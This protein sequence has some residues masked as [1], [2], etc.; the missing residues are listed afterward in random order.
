[1]SITDRHRVL[2]AGKK[3]KHYLVRI[4]IPLKLSEPDKHKQNPVDQAIQNLKDGLSKISNA[5][6]KEVIAYH[7]KAMDYLC[8]INNYV[9]REIIG[10][11]LPFE[12]FWGEDARHINDSVKVMGAGV[13]PEL[14]F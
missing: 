4:F 14:Y 10:N 9:D 13:L 1:M 5:C 7:F 6:G 11:Q 2:G 3:W 8:N 12:E